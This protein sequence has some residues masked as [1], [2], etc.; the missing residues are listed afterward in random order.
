MRCGQD[1]SVP[2][3]LPG[4]P[5]CPATAADSSWQSAELLRAQNHGVAGAQQ[6]PPLLLPGFSVRAGARPGPWRH[7]GC[8]HRTCTHAQLQSHGRAAAVL[9]VKN[10][11]VVLAATS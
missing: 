4:C 1:A 8:L 6:P 10:H 9:F 3:V 11:H 7:T 5:P 2:C